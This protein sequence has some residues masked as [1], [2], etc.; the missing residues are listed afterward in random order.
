MARL[1]VV[2][3]ALFAI[4]A[5]YPNVANYNGCRLPGSSRG[6]RHFMC[7]FPRGH[8][9]VT[10]ERGDDGKL[11]RCTNTFLGKRCIDLVE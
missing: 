6:G 8:F 7:H 1:L 2:L 3:L 11:K 9:H 5:A 10:I 4:V